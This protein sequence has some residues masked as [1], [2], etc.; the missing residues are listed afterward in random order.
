MRWGFIFVVCP[1]PLDEEQRLGLVNLAA[2]TWFEEQG[3]VEFEWEGA[4]GSLRIGSDVLTL[5]TFVGQRFV[6]EVH[7]ASG[8]SGQV[9]FLVA[10]K[11]LAEQVAGG[12][13]AEA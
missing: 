1:L 13:V 2:R 10:E 5:G 11:V 4:R 7:L 6:A 8:Q 3:L 9:E 12:V